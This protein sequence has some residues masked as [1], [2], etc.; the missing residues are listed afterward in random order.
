MNEKVSQIFQQWDMS[1]LRLKHEQKGLGTADSVY[2]PG[3]NTHPL[4]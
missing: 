3:Q 1:Q 2:A 4:C